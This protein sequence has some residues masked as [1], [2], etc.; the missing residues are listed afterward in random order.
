M[1][2]YKKPRLSESEEELR[3]FSNRWPQGVAS[4]RM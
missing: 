1:P 3:G 2:G 4:A